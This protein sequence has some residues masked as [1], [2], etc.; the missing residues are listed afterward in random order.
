MSFTRHT[1]RV[2]CDLIGIFFIVIGI[3]GL[4]LPFL[5]GI[6]FILIGLYFLSLHNMWIHRHLHALKHKHSKLAEVVDAI[7]L[8][9]RKFLHIEHIE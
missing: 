5:Q 8:K 4:F 1:K 6:L 3:A 9:V 2:I 7:D